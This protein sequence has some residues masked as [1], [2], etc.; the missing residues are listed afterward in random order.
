M[1]GQTQVQSILERALRATTRVA[2]TQADQSVAVEAFLLA[3]DTH[4]TRFANNIIH[5]NV[6]EH[7]T[8]LSLRA[9]LPSLRTGRRVGMSVTND[10]SDAGLGRAAETA[11]ALARLQPENPEFPGLPQ[12][13]A[14][15]HVAA[16]DEATAVF[17]PEARARAVQLICR[18]A[19]ES[20][21][22]ASGAFET[23]VH[24]MGVANSLGVSGYFPTTHADLQT[25]VMSDDSSGWA[26]ASGWR[27]EDVD[28]AAL[29]DEAI[30]KALRARG[31]RELEPGEY[32]VVLDAY[33]VADLLAMLSGGMGAQAFQEGRSWMS[34][35]LGQALMASSISI[36]DDG[37]DPRGLPLPFDGEGTPR[38]RV[39]IV[40]AGVT[41]N[42][43]YDTMTAAREAGRRTTGHA[44]PPFNPMTLAIGPIPQHLFLAPGNATLDDMIAATERGLYI[45]RHHYTRMVHPREAIVTGMTRDGTF[46]IEKGEI[47]YP[48]K[49]LR[50]TQSYVQAL[51]GVEM[52]GRE[53]RLLAGWLGAT[54]V[55]ALK[56]RAFTYTGATE[57]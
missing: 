27:V 45:T 20:G 1:L 22:I 44:L 26:Q 38:Q 32:P 10:L 4:L 25:V 9:V 57:F 3:H 51:A 19:R 54:C 52:I 14:I 2:P 5:Q 42:P 41:V 18:R 36:W 48:I 30:A 46:V 21:L 35:R 53:T 15:P 23:A 6:S 17:S 39:D 7:D 11:L 55:P 56:L 16:F 49:N 12:P 43:V 31:P 40:R 37:L 28:T 8:L 33:A 13:E 29:G 24:E 50:F 34:G 47:A